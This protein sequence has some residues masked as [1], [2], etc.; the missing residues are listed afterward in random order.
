MDAFSLENKTILVTGASG[1][2][3]SAHLRRLASLKANVIGLVRDASK[4]AHI[5]EASYIEID[6]NQDTS[7]ENLCSSID[8]L[9]GI[10]HCAGVVQPFPI[11]FLS[12]DKLNETM[13]INFDVPVKLTRLLLK[14]KKFNESASHV[15]I[16]SISADYPHKGGA[17]YASSKAALQAFS[18]VVALETSHLKM[19]AN[20]I[21]PAMIKTA[22][23]DVAEKGMS[24]E[25]MDEHISHYPLGMGYPEDVANT[26]AFLLSDASRW[27]TGI[28]ITLDGGFLLE[29]K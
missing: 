26:S 10:V 11:K 5:D 12:E 7:L 6:Y 24:K 15:F 2:I 4:M 29:G 18:K 8:Q 17:A 14:K 3:G 25:N 13:F 19:R 22:M 9:D 27:I 16:S 28:N 20:C 21:S 1:G 23:Y